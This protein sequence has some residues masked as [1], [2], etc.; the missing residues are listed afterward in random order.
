M[1]PF[2]YWVWK[3]KN[4]QSLFWGNNFQSLVVTSVIRAIP[5]LDL[6]PAAFISGVYLHLSLQ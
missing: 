4:S 6:N 1:V 3:L 2:G 5:P